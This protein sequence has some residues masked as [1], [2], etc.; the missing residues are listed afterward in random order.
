MKTKFYYYQDPGHGWAAVP[1]SLL[2]QLNIVGKISAFSYFRGR[3]AYLEEDCD[4]ALFFEAYRAEFGVDPVL[5]SK[6]TDK[7]SP[8]RSYARFTYSPAV[9]RQKIIEAAVDAGYIQF[10]TIGLQKDAA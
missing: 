3:T 5:I 9:R 2:E 10:L 4:L 6:H 1:V 8:I 7:R